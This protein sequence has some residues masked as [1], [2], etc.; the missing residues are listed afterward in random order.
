MILFYTDQE[1]DA[2]SGLYNY[3]ARLYDPI[4]GRFVS[5]D[6]LIPVAVKIIEADLD[7][8]EIGP[9]NFNSKALDRYAYVQNNPFIYVDPTGHEVAVVSRPLPGIWGKLGFMHSA[10]EINGDIQGYHA[11]GTGGIK[12][13]S[14]K[15]Y[16]VTGTKRTVVDPT[17]KSDKAYKSF[18]EDKKTQDKYS[19]D[20]YGALGNNCNDLVREALQENNDTHVQVGRFNGLMSTDDSEN[21]GIGKDGSGSGGGFDGR[22]DLGL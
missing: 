9:D 18:L 5:A 22:A 6:S 13:E 12:S 3:D 17:N 11:G 21:D 20:K 2:E 16:Q 10:L 4:V 7:K 14:S 8:K 15:D 19:E 1:L